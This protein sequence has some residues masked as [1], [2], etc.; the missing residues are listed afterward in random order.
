MG[1]YKKQM[2]QNQVNFPMP[3]LK[4]NIPQDQGAEDKGKIHVPV[5]LGEVLRYLALQD[6]KIYVDATFG[7]GGYSEAILKKGKT[8]V[9]AIDRDPEAQVPARVLKERFPERFQFLKGNFGEMETLLLEKGIS[10]VQG[11]VFDLGVSSPQIDRAERGFSFQKEGP[12]DM[13]MGK[14]GLTAAEVINTFSEADL[15]DIFYYYG[16]ETKSRK[17][18]RFIVKSRLNRE[19]C[20][21]FELVEIIHSVLGR[22]SGKI[23]SATRV[24]QALRIY[25]NDELGELEKGLDASLKLLI[26]G[27]HLIVVTFHS[28]EDRIV[29][30]FFKKHSEKHEEFQSPYS[31]AATERITQDRLPAL[32]LLTRR[33]VHPDPQ[34]VSQNPRSRSAKLRAVVKTESPLQI[35]ER[36]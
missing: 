17:V 36:V 27:G 3:D 12:L 31:Q 28:L 26:P 19:I 35:M 29:K 4:K 2:T 32:I 11:I 7:G 16:D 14:K 24:F 6:G 30:N 23:D 5:M 33:V 15:A 25:I 34:E 10:Q 13:R 21:T 18:A 8:R 20:T 22:K 9:I 1:L